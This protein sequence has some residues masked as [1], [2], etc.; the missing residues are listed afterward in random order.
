MLKHGKTGADFR[1]CREYLGYSQQEAAD[2][3]GCNRHTVK[4]WESPADPWTPSDVA[5][6]WIERELEWRDDEVSRM[7]DI[8]DDIKRQHG[9]KLDSV[10]LAI[11]HAND[12]MGDLRGDNRPSG[13][14]N[15]TAR[16]VW[17]YLNDDGTSV[18]FSWAMDM[19][20]RRDTDVII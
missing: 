2:N 17:Q 13:V 20:P 12:G 16:E 18:Y 1:M 10:T 14:H 9:G 6:E 19:D 15:A 3:I 4:R 5:W 7:L 8:A 11:F